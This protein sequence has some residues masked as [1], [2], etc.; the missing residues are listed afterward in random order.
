[1]SDPKT[2]EQSQAELMAA[3]EASIADAKTPDPGV[4]A[5]A[6]PEPAV[7]PVADPVATP[8]DPDAPAADPAVEPAKPATEPVPAD[9][10]A[11]VAPAKKPSD[12]LGEIEANAPAT[13]KARFDTLKTK[14]DEQHARADENERIA[15]Q[16]IDTVAGTKATPDQF[17]NS[18][19]YLAD[20]NSGT[21][22]GLERAYSAIKGEYD[23]LAKAL[24]REGP[25]VDPLKD[26][27]DLLDK[28][29]GGML[30]REDALEI[31][32]HRAAKNIDAVTASTQAS[33]QQTVADQTDAIEGIKALGN[34]LRASDP[35]FHAKTQMM[36]PI[37]E[38]IQASGA[39]PSK[40]V[41]LVRAAY[42]K[43]PVMAPAPAPVAAAAPNSLRPNGAGSGTGGGMDKT[44]GSAMEAVK[45]ALGRGY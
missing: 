26:H 24:G 38:A 29:E 21:R 42:S 5:D 4:T 1:M 39:H 43:I 37:I 45:L 41:E 3:V 7:E 36:T 20:I 28:V 25:G 9:P 22:D 32:A 19:R 8:A 11:P 40:W 16:W 2:P 14:Y 23:L 35:H 34:A 15:R 27:K 12:E 33:S 6:P 18:L 44:P 17:T 10:F 31:A 13:T 30:D